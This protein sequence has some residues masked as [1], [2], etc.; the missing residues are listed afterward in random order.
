M[1]TTPSE[2]TAALTARIRARL[3]SQAYAQAEA[4]QELV[5]KK[6]RSRA[7]LGPLVAGQFE[8]YYGQTLQAANIDFRAVQSILTASVKKATEL[9]ED[10]ISRNIGEGETIA[11]VDLT[12][13]ESD[14][15]TGTV[16]GDG[17]HVAVRML[18]NYRYGEN[19]ANGVLTVYPQF[20]GSRHGRPLP[21][22][23]QQS[24]ATA[25]KEAAKAERLAA[26]AARRAE[27]RAKFAK[28]P[29]RLARQCEKDIEQ[30]GTDHPTAPMWAHI[31]D[32]ARALTVEQLDQMFAEGA[33]TAGDIE[34]KFE[35]PYRLAQRAA[36]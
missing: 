3:L 15:I 28:A 6:L 31:R 29:E 22:K 18:W 10:R 30:W 26:K 12:I 32:A 2:I 14:L 13:H 17:F 9:L 21:G 34:W 19:S 5:G 23:P 4:A 27:L 7:K 25:A 24:T 36:S 8:N 11:D 16:S 33:R 35:R 1:F 20:R